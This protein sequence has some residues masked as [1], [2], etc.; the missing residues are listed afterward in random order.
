MIGSERIAF[1][2]LQ[3]FVVNNQFVLK[4][5][6]FSVKSNR[7]DDNIPSFHYIFCE[8][9]AW[10]YLSDM[11]RKK[12]MWLSTFHHGFYWK[13]G[14]LSYEK[15]NTCIA[16]LAEKNLIIYV[17]GQQKVNWLKQLCEN[18]EIDCRNIY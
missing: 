10:K 17:K 13:Q 6:C 5:I 9:F 4:E 12:A 14:E 3:G 15:I 1:V 2:D 16:P 7:H 8:P 18:I 11:C